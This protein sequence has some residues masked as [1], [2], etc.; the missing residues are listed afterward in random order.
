MNLDENFVLLETLRR[1]K[2]NKQNLLFTHPVDIITCR[3]KKEI[4]RC[5]QR[6]EKYLHEGFY[7][8]GF[9]AYELG[10]ALEDAFDAH[11]AVSDYPLL[12]FGVYSDVIKRPLRLPENVNDP[13]R[14]YLTQPM[15]DISV[16][17]YTKAISKVRSLIRAGDTYQI[18]FTSQYSFQVFG[19]ALGL[20]QALKDHQPVSYSALINYG[21]NYIISV[22]PE[23]FFRID[24]HRRITVKPMKGTAPADAP[25]DWLPSDAKNASENVM[26]VD[27]LR[28]DLG[29]ICTPGSVNVREL[30]AVEKYDTLQQMTSTVTGRLKSQIRI[31]EVVKS[32][33]PSGSITGAPKI[34]SMQ[35]IRQLEKKPRNIYTG[36]VGYFS[37]D[38]QAVFNVAIRTVDLQK[39]TCGGFQAAMGVGGGIVFDSKPEAEYEE[40]RLKAKFLLKAAQD[41]GLIETMLFDQRRIRHLN[42]HLRRLKESAN[43]F[44][45]PCSSSKIR[46]AL[47]QYTQGWSG[48]IR[49]R[50]ILQSNGEIVLEYG[51]VAATPENPAVAISEFQTFSGDPFL[52]HKTTH[53]KLYHTEYERHVA[54]GYFDVIFQNEKQQITEGAISNIFI[55]RRGRWYTPPLACGLLCGIERGLMMKKFRARERIL[56]LEDIYHADKI[57]LT[58]SVRGATE[59]TLAL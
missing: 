3:S 2:H 46:A 55:Q 1:D 54:K 25:L 28:N 26:I 36:A 24:K 50:L 6:M 17:D 41:F 30:F 10:Y 14:Y 45:I 48:K 58:N 32:L 20:Y 44:S 7:L 47:K 13:S 8:A 11:K 31:F 57:V 52:Y 34:R 59:V 33:F 22:S 43:F 18:N 9:M 5:F 56:Y 40:C 27:L 53:R 15:L 37:P 12:W 35:I 39:K 4:Y 49:L 42:R 23:L 21:G 16:S 29:R 51:P 38:G 19:N